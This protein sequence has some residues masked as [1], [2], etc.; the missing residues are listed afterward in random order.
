VHQNSRAWAHKESITNQRNPN[1]IKN[2]SKNKG[3]QAPSQPSIDQ[4]KLSPP[5][6][7]GVAWEGLDAETLLPNFHLSSPEFQNQAK[8]EEW[9]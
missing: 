5:L 7:F 1:D 9:L 3:A 2:E 4:K 8:L 6:D